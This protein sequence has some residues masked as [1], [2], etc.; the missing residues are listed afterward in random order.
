MYKTENRRQKL[1][2]IKMPGLF[3]ISQNHKKSKFSLFRYSNNVFL[4]LKFNI[5]LLTADKTTT[6]KVN[7]ISFYCRWILF[8]NHTMRGESILVYIWF[9]GIFCFVFVVWYMYV[10]WRTLC[11]IL[12]IYNTP[13]KILSFNFIN[14]THY[15]VRVYLLHGSCFLF[16]REKARL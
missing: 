10:P 16:I 9:I 4:F 8:L 3:N 15:I 7:S 5:N 2:I 1:V 11:G 14:M 13:V 12:I 6:H